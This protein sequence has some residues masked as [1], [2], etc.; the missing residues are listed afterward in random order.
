MYRFKF[1]HIF[2]LAIRLMTAQATSAESERAFSQAEQITN[3]MYLALAGVY[4][5]IG[6]LY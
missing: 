4:K 5:M 6:F 1:S 3:G 2:E